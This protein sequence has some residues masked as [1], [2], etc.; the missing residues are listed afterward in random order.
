M[1]LSAR[2]GAS[3]ADVAYCPRRTILDGLLVDAA[4]EAG[5]EVREGF[6]VDEILMSPEEEGRVIG[7][8]GH[9]E[10]GESVTELARVVIGADGRNSLVARAV[11]AE[12]YNEKP[13]AQISYYTYFSNLPIDGFQVY[14][15]LS[16][17]CA[18][19][20]THGDLTLVMAGW[21]IEELERN[22]KDVEG[23][24][25]KALEMA[26]SLA[27]RI[28]GPG[29]TAKREARFMGMS[30]PNYFRKPFGPGWALV[31]DAGYSKD[32]AMAM[33]ILDAFRDA[34]LCANALDDVFSGRASFDDRMRDGYHRVRDEQ[35][36]PIYELNH[37]L[38]R[39][40][41]PPPELQML[42]GA[43]HRDETATADF[44]QVASGVLSPA[45][46]FAERVPRLMAAAL[47]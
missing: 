14:L 11:R 2:P 32:F 15:G 42:L 40:E 17:G 10:S 41:P 5:V 7:V 34:E 16:R 43:I 18:A 4:A 22:R 47:P 29:A 8:R 23:N 44:I 38:A 45:E 24:Y 13:R 30:V 27:K 12:P 37:Q 26:P 20:P 9:D 21:P 3:D 33:G 36:L 25:L 28:S 1:A 46:F 35:V 6:R 39:L 19:I 31:G